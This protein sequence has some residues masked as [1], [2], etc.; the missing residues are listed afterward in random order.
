VRYKAAF[1]V[2]ANT[3]RDTPEVQVV[4][5]AIGT[6]TE[7]ELLF[8]PGPVGMVN[9]QIYHLEHQLYPTTPGQSFIGHD[10]HITI[11]DRYDLRDDPPQLRLFGWSPG[12]S[13]DHTVEISFTVAPLVRRQF[14]EITQV[15]LPT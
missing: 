4:N 7:I 10:T 5:L 9:I 6:L 12:T 14:V 2:P 13:Y 8:P 11:A 3:P 15:E 1:T